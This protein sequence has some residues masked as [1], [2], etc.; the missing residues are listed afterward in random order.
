MYVIQFK[1]IG[2]STACLTAYVDQHQRNIKVR[3]AAPTWD[4]RTD[5]W[6]IPRTKNK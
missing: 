2:Y 5:D 3:V 6:W 4:E 1:I